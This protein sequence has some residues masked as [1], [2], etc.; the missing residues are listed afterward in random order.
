[1][2][3]QMKDDIERIVHDL[4]DQIERK[5]H[6][7]IDLVGD[8]RDP[9][10]LT[11]ISTMLGVGDEDR[12]EFH[13]LME[14]FVVRL[15][16][17]SAVDALRAVPDSPEALRGPRAVGGAATCRPRRRADLGPPVGERGRRLAQ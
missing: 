11:V 10:P 3:Q 6:E 17:G 2:V 9:L 1:M 8:C 4:L 13:L 7:T 12:D 16:S 15:G 14:R 5:G